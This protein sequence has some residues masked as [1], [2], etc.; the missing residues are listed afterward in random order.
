[1]RPVRDVIQI[2]DPSDVRQAELAALV[3]QN[4][5]LEDQ[6]AQ[7]NRNLKEAIE[8]LE[9]FARNVSHDLRA[10]LRAIAGYS[11]LLLK[12]LPAE[13]TEQ[14]RHYL[15]RI[16]KNCLH[17]GRLIDELLRFSRIGREALEWSTVDV[18][19]V[20]QSCIEELD[21][22]L[23][24][25]APAIAVDD[26]PPCRGDWPLLKQVFINLLSNAIKYS[27]DAAPPRIAITGRLDRTCG[28]VVYSVSDN[29]VGF[30]MA[31]ADQLFEVFQRL[32]RAEDYEG[33]GLGLALC[34]RIIRRHSG[35]IWAEAEVARGATFYV[36]LP[37]DRTLRM[38]RS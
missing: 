35:R 19:A 30:D 4:E 2:E 12:D 36:A 3:N 6:V 10:P 25:G 33:T 29:G 18:N 28:E 23:V 24:D 34:Q 7:G 15:E 13:L 14:P 38:R 1:M 8:D 26:L 21:E 20:V 16:N 32:H 31:Y 27:R 11:E 22:G 17:M 37:A 9:G 5:V